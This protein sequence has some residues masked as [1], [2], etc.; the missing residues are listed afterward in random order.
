MA[1]WFP[2]NRNTS[3]QSRTSAP[4][5][6]SS[7]SRTRTGSRGTRGQRRAQ[8]PAQGRSRNRSVRGALATA[9]RIGQRA[10]QSSKAKRELPTTMGGRIRRMGLA[11]G[12]PNLAVSLAI[13]VIALAVT[14]LAGSPL[15]WLPTAI[16]DMWLVFNAAGV[17]AAGITISAVPMLPALAVGGAVASR[18]YYTVKDHVS[19]KDLIVLLLCVITVP[20]VLYGI[21]WGMLWDASKV[22]DVAP[23]DFF[24]SLAKVEALHLAAAALGMGPRLWKAIARRYGIPVDL[25][26][27]ARTAVKY[28]GILFA[29]S[30]LLYIGLLIAGIGRIGEM[31]AQYPNQG[32]LALLCLWGLSLFYA[33]NLAVGA[34]STVVGSEAHI[35]DASISLF[36][37]HLVPLPPLPALGAIPGGAA[38]W[39][40]VFMVVPV[41]CAA[42]VF[43]RTKATFA[44][45]A[46]TGL[47]TFAFTGLAGYLASGQLGHYGHTGVTLLTFAG[48][49]AA[50]VLVTGA[51]IAAALKFTQRREEKALEP[52]ES[53]VALE[54]VVDSD[55]VAE[56]KVATEDTDE[57]PR[58][59]SEDN[60]GE[61]TEEDPEAGSEESTE[62]DTEWGETEKKD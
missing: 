2:M 1:K 33:P 62:E 32:P 18:V 20:A 22:Y 47:A 53:D 56:D 38:P 44:L 55:E 34:A 36:S 30:G 12:I 45:A 61:D 41:A 58:V 16:A 24:A 49:N 26:E 21:A 35:G 27:G 28:L 29:A 51:A 25:I 59:E 17:S 31:M 6:S 23:P 7:R 48:F 57:A 14:L 42:Y 15:A 40:M 5:A 3:P 19:I 39:A 52:E 8:A 13:V 43:L 37:I 4:S 60:S 54:D 50:W 9:A 11:V 10:G 46:A